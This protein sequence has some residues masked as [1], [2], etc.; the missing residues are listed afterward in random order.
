M[1]DQEMARNLGLLITE[2]RALRRSVEEL[3]ARTVQSEAS[4]RRSRWQIRV[5]AGVA[6]LGLGLTW[7]VG[8]LYLNQRDTDARLRAS[9]AAQETLRSKAV[10]PLYAL[11]LDYYNPRSPAARQ[12][13]AKYEAVFRRLREQTGA[14]ECPR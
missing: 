1:T 9:I 8:L 2:T 4:I 13:P 11:L 7:I 3:A 5:V 14:L 10:C 12:N 6:V